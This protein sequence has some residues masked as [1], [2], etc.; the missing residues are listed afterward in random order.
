MRDRCFHA[1]TAIS[2]IVYWLSELCPSTSEHLIVLVCSQLSFRK[3]AFLSSTRSFHFLYWAELMGLLRE[4]GTGIVFYCKWELN[5]AWSLLKCQANIINAFHNNITFDWTSIYV[6]G[7]ESI[8]QEM[9]TVLKY[10]FR[11]M[12]HKGQDCKWATGNVL[13]VLSAFQN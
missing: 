3:T 5:L 13:V 9:W 7:T 12:F 6:V 8:T 4:F 11:L 10:K 1:Y 2:S